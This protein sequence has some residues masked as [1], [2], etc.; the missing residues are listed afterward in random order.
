MYTVE[1]KSP[2]LTTVIG[3][4]STPTFYEGLLSPPSSTANLHTVLKLFTLTRPGVE[5]TKF[6]T[7]PRSIPI[8]E[9]FTTDQI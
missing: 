1:K 5:K 7:H 8:I 4:K 2:S 9:I 6:V 3:E